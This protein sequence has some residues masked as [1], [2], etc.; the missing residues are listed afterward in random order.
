RKEYNK[1]ALAKPEAA[2]TE[3]DYFA[4][5]HIHTLC[6]DDDG[7]AAIW[8]HGLERF[9]KSALLHY[10]MMT[11]ELYVHNQV[12]SAAQLWADAERLEKKS[13]LDE[14]YRHWLRAALDDFRREYEPAVAEA[15]AAVAMAPYDS[16]SHSALSWLMSD[17]EQ[18]DEAI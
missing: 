2:R 17:A 16:F 9:P 18:Y 15:R 7:A 10:K 1:I 4:L 14:W 12:E 3:Y 13:R 8:R 6:A 5:G 11:Y